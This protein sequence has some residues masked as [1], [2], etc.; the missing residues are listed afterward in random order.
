M[1]DSFLLIRRASA[2]LTGRA[3]G[4]QVADHQMSQEI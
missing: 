3:I 4:Y 1:G 2:A